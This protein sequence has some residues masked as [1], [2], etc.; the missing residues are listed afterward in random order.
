MRVSVSVGSVLTVER[1]I[2]QAKARTADELARKLLAG[3]RRRTPVDTGLAK[4]S[5]SRRKEGN[6]EVIVNKQPYTVFLDRGS[7]RQAPRGI[8]KPA[9][10]AVLS[11]RI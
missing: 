5:W 1:Q 3:V 6:D 9:I 11:R 2:Q 8:T 10:K 4:A 7:S